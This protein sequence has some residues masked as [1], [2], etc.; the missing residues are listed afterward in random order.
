M[1]HPRNYLFIALCLCSFLSAYAQ[2]PTAQP[3]TEAQVREYLNLMRVTETMKV[4]FDQMMTMMRR[5]PAY[6]ALPDDFWDTMRKK[7]DAEEMDKLIGQ[8]VPIYQKHYTGDDLEAAIAFYRSPAGQRLT[9]KQPIIT[10]E[11]QEAG[12]AWGRE[13]GARVAREVELAPKKEK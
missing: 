12:Y 4:S 2:T 11:S 1:K 3:P 10:K 9:A 13:L 6:K 8:I 7:L 5:N